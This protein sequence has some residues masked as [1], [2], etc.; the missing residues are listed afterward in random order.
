MEGWPVLGDLVGQGLFEG[1]HA[2]V[3]TSGCDH[4]VDGC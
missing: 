2:A 1:F 4:D 3:M